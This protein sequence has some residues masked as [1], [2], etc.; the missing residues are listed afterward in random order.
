MAGGRTKRIENVVSPS[1]PD[2][3]GE[4]DFPTL[5]LPA[6]WQS[7]VNALLARYR[8]DSRLSNAPEFTQFSEY[9]EEQRLPQ[10]WRERNGFGES[11]LPGRQLFFAEEWQTIA[12]RFSDDELRER[13]GWTDRRIVTAKD[14]LS[15]IRHLVRQAVTTADENYEWLLCGALPIRSSAGRDAVMAFGFRES[16]FGSDYTWFG[17]FDDDAEFRDWLQRSGWCTGMGDL[18]ALGDAVLAMWD[19]G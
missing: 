16:T 19:A 6:N 8:A 7:V 18:K 2:M 5:R 3:G 9:C 13:R 1:A 10:D 11:P 12:S 4:H 14:R 15:E 17:V